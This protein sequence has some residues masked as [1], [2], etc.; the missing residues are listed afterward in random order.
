MARL[1]E[2]R[3]PDSIV[4]E[5]GR[6]AF[7]ALLQ[8]SQPWIDF[9]IELACKR[10][11]AQ[12]SSKGEIAREAMAVIAHVRDPIERDQY[13]KTMARKLDVSESALRALRPT[14]AQPA[15]PGGDGAQPVRR[16]MPPPMHALSAERELVALI[17][18]Q[19][20]FIEAVAGRISGEDFADD[21]MARAYAVLLQLRG[22]LA[23]GINPLTLLADE[24]NIAE[25]T[26]LALSSPP[27]RPDEEEQRLERILERFDRQRLER[28]L[29]IIDAEMNR[30]LT[31]GAS[32]PEPLRDEYN[33]L[34]AKLRGAAAERKEGT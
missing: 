16:A 6:D 14:L 18:V 28:R 5:D 4:L 25:L 27:L 13:V 24:T 33:S 7:S 30:L 31:K 29:S 21:E 1:P 19:P 9:K 22:D 3:D 32:V 12:F 15:R 26:H 2:G 20:K 11:S 23:R 34:A 8:A 10:I 17:L